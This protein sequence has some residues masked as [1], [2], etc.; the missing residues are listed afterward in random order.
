MKVEYDEKTDTLT[1]S[2]RDARIRESD[3]VRPGVIADF[4]DDGGIVHFEVLDASR[5]VE[6]TREMQFALVGA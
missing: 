2:L 5:V 1:I 6:H 3:E 4:G